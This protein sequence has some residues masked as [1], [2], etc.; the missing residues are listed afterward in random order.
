MNKSLLLTTLLFYT[1]NKGSFI[2]M[3]NLIYFY[4]KSNFGSS[5]KVL[6]KAFTHLAKEPEF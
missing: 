4:L 3:N 5:V 6:R 1:R 2:G